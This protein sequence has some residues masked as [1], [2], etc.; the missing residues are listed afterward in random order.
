LAGSRLGR[1]AGSPVPGRWSSGRLASGHPG[2]PERSPVSRS[3]GPRCPGLRSCRLLSMGESS[4]AFAQSSNHSAS[5]SVTPA[6][7]PGSLLH[8]ECVAAADLVV[9][10]RMTDYGCLARSLQRSGSSAGA[11]TPLDPSVSDRAFV[12]ALDSKGALGWHLN[13]E[14]VTCETSAR[15][16]AI[17]HFAPAGMQLLACRPGWVG[18]AGDGVAEGGIGMGRPHLDRVT[19]FMAARFLRNAIAA[20]SCGNCPRR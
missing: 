14:W 1:C 9:V 18:T 16:S 6:C 8:C 7:A 10:R 5:L 11:R 20:A 4:R 13:A 12:R 3:L 2:S 15:K 17:G 19:W